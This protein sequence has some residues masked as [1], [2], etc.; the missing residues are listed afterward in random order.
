[1]TL[2]RRQWFATLLKPLQSKDEKPDE[3]PTDNAPA[4]PR[5]AVV[6]GRECLAYRHLS[7]TV[8]SEHCPEP[9][10]II[11]ERGIPRINPAACTGCG[12]CHDVCPAPTNA[13][14]LIPTPTN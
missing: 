9:G 5:T 6:K 13:I 14:L 1:M 8:C 12:I 7:C 3:L 4:T 10:A 2:S 11:V